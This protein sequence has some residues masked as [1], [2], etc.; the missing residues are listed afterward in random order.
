MEGDL[1]R[2]MRD[3]VLSYLETTQ[4]YDFVV[5]SVDDL[6]KSQIP[7]ILKESSITIEEEETVHTVNVQNVKIDRASVHDD[8][9]NLGVDTIER[10]IMSNRTFVANVMVDVAISSE[11]RDRK[12]EFYHTG[13]KLCGLPICVGSFG[14]KAD[15]ATVPHTAIEAAF[16]V[17]GIPKTILTQ[18]TMTTNYIF[19]F[20]GAKSGTLDLEVR[21]L[22][23]ST[24]WCS[25]STL[26]MTLDTQRL[27]CTMH[28]PFFTSNTKKPLVVPLQHAFMLCGTHK[29]EDVLM[30]L[31][32]KSAGPIGEAQE[33]QEADI[34]VRVL[35]TNWDHNQTLDSLLQTYSTKLRKDKDAV[36]SMFRYQFVPHTEGSQTDRE[37]PKKVHFLI[38]CL[39]RLCAVMDGKRKID[40]RD[41]MKN[42]KVNPSGALLGTLFRQVYRSFLQDISKRIKAFIDKNTNQSIEGVV[43][44]V[45]TSQTFSSRILS[46][47]TSGNLSIFSQK[48]YFKAQ[49]MYNTLT[50]HSQCR[51]VA[52]D[53]HKESKTKQPRL[54]HSS[55]YG[56]LCC[57][58]TVDGQQTGIV[59]T[60]TYTATVSQ[61]VDVSNIVPVIEGI[62]TSLEAS[63]GEPGKPASVFCNGIYAGSTFRV[64]DALQQIRSYRRNGVL[65]KSISVYFDSTCDE[66]LVRCDA[67]RML[68]P[69]WVV[70]SLSRLPAVLSSMRPFDNLFTIL[71]QN[72]IVE[73]LDPGE[74][75]SEEILVAPSL[76]YV[77][78]QV[79]PSGSD[80]THAHLHSTCIFSRVAACIPF[81]NHNAGPRNTYWSGSQ[82]K[83]LISLQTQYSEP[84]HLSTT[85]NYSLTYAQRA[86]CRTFLEKKEYKEQMTPGINCCVLIAAMG[87]NIED[88]LIVSKSALERGL[89]QYFKRTPLSLE[90]DIHS[91]FK[92]LCRPP[93]NVQNQMLK[94]SYDKLQETGLP[95]V[96]T[97]ID[98]GD[99]VIGCVQRLESTQ[100]V[101]WRCCS[102]QST[103]SGKVLEIKREAT[104]S[105]ICVTVV[106]GKLLSPQMG[107]K[108]CSRHGQK[109]TIGLVMQ[110]TDLPWT[111]DGMQP[112]LIFNSHG[113]P[114]RMTKGQLFESAAGLSAVA[115]GQDTFD[116]SAFTP[117]QPDRIRSMLVKAGLHSSG[118]RTFYSGTTG[119]PI[120][121]E[122][123][124]GLVHYGLLKHF[125][126]DKEQARGVRGRMDSRT[127][128]PVGGRKNGGG[129]RFGEMERGGV[130]AHGASS[131]LKSILSVSSDGTTI[132]VCK[133]CRQRC[134]TIKKPH[135]AC[136]MCGSSN[137]VKVDSTHSS[138]LL[139]TQLTSLGISTQFDILD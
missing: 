18:L 24:P 2:L 91:E 107:D 79:G 90:I 29:L 114:S 76:H 80:F 54:L 46:A 35:R 128:Q 139:M 43:M 95:A 125:V 99:V 61:P 123:Y 133:M 56:Y 122:L 1:E 70:E 26:Q 112:D 60:L 110:Q 100:G 117:N 84:R 98:V 27:I 44:Q 59:N 31:H 67:G 9:G 23:D 96:G 130:T 103:Y 8:Y 69:C 83:S 15:T 131:L 134:T 32:L 17:N 13:V 66:I 40:S 71:E 62:L 11:F 94:A 42:K 20:D 6:I 89:F 75:C 78:Q 138:I 33:A 49:D 68:K 104:K 47:F 121:A 113:L 48:R 127:K 126:A 14:G 57:A 118:M 37:S 77:A 39:K 4:P 52:T 73:W 82:A 19:V 25:T 7:K 63:E 12:E 136:M 124:F 38:S 88:C 30:L 101:Q 116:A 105:N 64:A 74:A 10:C 109:G 55:A 92:V 137:V 36:L 72:G 119:E 3:T 129:Q 115:S 28:V 16:I 41:H 106:L 93:P 50:A 21:S 81:A 132:Y 65:P 120:E 22:R 58:A 53:L 34:L 86:V 5:E 111:P 87:H 51:Q 108:L 102:L 135:L 97:Y 85:T 45:F